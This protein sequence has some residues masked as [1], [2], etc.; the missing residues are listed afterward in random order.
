MVALR[1]T[2][3]ICFAIGKRDSSMATIITFPETRLGGAAIAPYT[4]NTASVDVRQEFNLHIDEIFR[5]F[6]CKKASLNDL[7]M[8]VKFIIGQLIDSAK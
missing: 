2:D 8:Q 3:S 7:S 4:A 1:F 5:E 6:E